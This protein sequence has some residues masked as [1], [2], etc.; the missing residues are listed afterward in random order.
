MDCTKVKYVCS[1]E[2]LQN[3]RHRDQR[4]NKFY[5]RVQIFISSK[6]PE[7][8][9]KTEVHFFLEILILSPHY[10]HPGNITLCHFQH[11]LLGGITEVRT[12]QK[13]ILSSSSQDYDTSQ[14]SLFYAAIWQVSYHQDP[15]AQVS[16]VSPT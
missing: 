8:W 6:T 10:R 11:F 13:P 4:R 5:L 7:V 3:W 16:K 2:I 9:D 14:G 15:Q 12:L 1:K